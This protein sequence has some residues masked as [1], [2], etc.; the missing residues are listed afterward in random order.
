MK[1]AFKIVTMNTH[2]TFF[3][4]EKKFVLKL[5]PEVFFEKVLKSSQESDD[6]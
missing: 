5:C 1:Q 4:T 3:N 6:R 2:P